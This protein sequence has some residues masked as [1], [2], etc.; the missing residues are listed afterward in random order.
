MKGFTLLEIIITIAVAGILLTIATNSYQVAQV[1]KNQDQI[2][3]AIEASLDEQRANTQAGK[4]GQNFGVKFNSDSF[5]LFTGTTY[6]ANSS[7]NKVIGIDSQFEISE[8]ITNSDNIIYFSKILGDA[9]Q[10]ATITISHITNRISPKQI[11]IEKSGTI[12]VIE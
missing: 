5:V 4:D 6:S 12:S 1:K 8:T 11:I 7:Q 3:Q 10:N 9:N 2:V